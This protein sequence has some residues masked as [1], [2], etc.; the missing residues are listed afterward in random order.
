MKLTIAMMALLM[1][2]T[3]FSQA[4]RG[5]E[6]VKEVPK[7]A[8]EQKAAE[9]ERARIETAGSANA[10]KISDGQKV[11]SNMVQAGKQV[12]AWKDAEGNPD[13]AAQDNF[14]DFTSKLSKTPDE[15][16]A[17]VAVEMMAE[18]QGLKA[19]ELTPE[20]RAEILKELMTCK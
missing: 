5:G 6:P 1:A 16:K 20:K 13:R 17:D 8:A 4:R 14:M 18:R 19:D 11:A 2:S 12:E 15:L 7:T 3:A 10:S 9:R